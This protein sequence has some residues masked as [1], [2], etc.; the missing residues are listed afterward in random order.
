M[1]SKVKK[2]IYG[3][4]YLVI[5]FLIGLW[6][7]NG[8][9]KP[10]PTCFDKIQNQSETGVDCSGPCTPCAVFELESLR[11]IGGVKIFSLSSGQAFLLAEVLNPNA[12][13]GAR[14]FSYR[15]NIYG[16]LD[17]PLETVAGTDFI[18]AGEDK[19]IFSL[20]VGSPFQEIGRVELKLKDPIWEK[21]KDFER[22]LLSSREVA[23][24]VGAKSIKIRG[25]AANKSSFDLREVDVLGV[26]FDRS[27]NELFVSKSVISDLRSFEEREFAVSFPDEQGLI[28]K[29]DKET[30]RVFLYGH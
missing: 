30:T 8:F 17:R 15:F 23:T 19:Y 18:Y 5:L 1:S 24:D 6:I 14:T 26:I 10:T 2:L 12:D 7:Y 13:Y 28:S 27:G 11:A 4:F 3:I 20:D 9:L 21:N 16:V 22:P 25:L 29:I